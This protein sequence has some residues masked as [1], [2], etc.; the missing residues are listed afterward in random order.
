MSTV[1]NRNREKVL[2]ELESFYESK[3]AALRAKRTDHSKQP[4]RESSA[5]ED[6]VRVHVNPRRK[7]VILSWE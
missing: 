3:L 7:Q 5:P 2:D 6:P 1:S 4:V